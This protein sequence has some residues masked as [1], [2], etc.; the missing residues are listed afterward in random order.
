MG[1]TDFYSSRRYYSCLLYTSINLMS[2]NQEL[3]LVLKS[4]EIG[5]RGMLEKLSLIHI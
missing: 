4:D 3:N 1:T 5:A 2:K